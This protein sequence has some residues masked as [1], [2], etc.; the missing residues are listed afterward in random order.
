MPIVAASMEGFIL[1]ALSAKGMSGDNLANFASVV[2]NASV[3]SIVG[4]TFNTEDSGQGN[5]AGVG[6]GT[7]L[8]NISSAQI[9]T[10]IF[11]AATQKFGQSGDNLKDFC[12]AVGDGL[13]QTLK[14]A[15][16]ISAHAPV[17]EGTGTIIAGSINVNTEEWAQN[18]YSQGVSAG[19]NGDKWADFANAIALGCVEAFSTCS[20]EVQISGTPPGSPAPVPSIINTVV[21]SGTIS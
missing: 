17:Y 21:P 10:N 14:L 2:A 7:G 5:G 15:T 19:F 16:L 1:N 4:K 6:E 18:L 20:G 9:S 12:D 11:N 3:L 8:T 13:E